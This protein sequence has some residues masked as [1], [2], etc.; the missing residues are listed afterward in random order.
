MRKH[1]P[2]S[3]SGCLFSEQVIL[4]ELDLYLTITSIQS[5]EIKFIHLESKPD[6]NVPPSDEAKTIRKGHQAM[7]RLKTPENEKCSVYCKSVSSIM[8]PKSLT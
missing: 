7:E 5:L 1:L 8:N 4:R 2:L 3:L 6:L